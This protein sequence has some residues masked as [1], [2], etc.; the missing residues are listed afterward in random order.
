LLYVVRNQDN[1]V[2]VIRLGTRLATGT[3]VRTLTDPAL[4]V[5]AAIDRFGKSR[6]AVNARF[7]TPPTATT[8]YQVVGVGK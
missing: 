1:L 5:P 4:D 2:V 3:I 8:P 7:S 6:Y